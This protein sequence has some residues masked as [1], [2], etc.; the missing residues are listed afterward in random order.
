MEEIAIAR[1]CLQLARESGAEQ[2]RI[3][4][5]KSVTN[6]A[7]M[8]NGELDKVSRSLDRSLALNLFVDGR[9]GSFST[10]RLDEAALPDFVRESIATVRMLSPIGSIH[11]FGMPER[12]L[13]MPRTAPQVA[14]VQSVSSPQ[15]T[16][17]QTDLPKSP[18][19]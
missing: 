19:P 17:R 10:N 9:Y 13:M 15:S 11:S 16:A 6:L 8:L 4:L 7:G 2:V 18:S 5:N 3:T 12:P 1:N 14:P